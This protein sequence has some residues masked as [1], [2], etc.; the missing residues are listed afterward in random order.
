MNDTFESKDSCKNFP[1]KGRD[2]F[3]VQRRLPQKPA[4][5]SKDFKAMSY[6]L[7]TFRKFYHP[8][9]WSQGLRATNMTLNTVTTLPNL[10]CA[11]EVGSKVK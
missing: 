5:S 8:I 3:H 1:L 11:V 4:V 2:W 7:G 6:P 9:K 10:G